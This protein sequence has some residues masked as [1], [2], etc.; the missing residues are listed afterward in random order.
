M[1][2]DPA[3]T[4]RVAMETVTDLLQWRARRRPD[5][6]AE[7]QTEAMLERLERAIARLD[8]L[9]A[10]G[11][12]RD[13]RAEGPNRGR[14]LE[15]SLETELLAILGAVSADMIAEATERAER[16]AGRLGTASSVSR[17]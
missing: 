2:S 1:V 11:P 17:R 3:H 9:T 6:D 8:E 13:R 16:L 7:V 12:N 5:L 4:I 10:E 14:R 15:R